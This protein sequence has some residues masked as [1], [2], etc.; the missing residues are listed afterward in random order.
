[1]KKILIIED[2]KDLIELLKIELE[3]E[4]YCVSYA[5][6]GEEGLEKYHQEQPDLI[7][8]D[9][10]LPKING[11]EVARVIRRDHNDEKTCILMLTAKTEDADRIVGRLRG[12]QEYMPKPFD[13]YTLLKKIRN[14]LGEGD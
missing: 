11:Y 1:M 10:M 8:L 6:S 2:E 4:S 12:A 14:L 7:I 9:L 3:S 5:Y 13:V